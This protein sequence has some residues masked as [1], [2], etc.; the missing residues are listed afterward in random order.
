MKNL[1]LLLILMALATT[2]MAVTIATE[3]FQHTVYSVGTR[4]CGA[5]VEARRKDDWYQMGQWILGYVSAAGFYAGYYKD[6]SL[7]DSDSGAF[8]T[9]MDNYCQQHPLELFETG[10][11]QLIE[12]LRKP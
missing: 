11:R 8:L 4:T 6:R 7:K 3:P 12:E 1:A 10:V 5:W 9:Y 2:A